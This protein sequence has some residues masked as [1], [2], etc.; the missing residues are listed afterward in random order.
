MKRAEFL[1]NVE[2]ILENREK[3]YGS[4]DAVFEAIA[5]M[6]SAYLTERTGIPVTVTK[7]D[8]AV[9]QIINKIARIGVNM[10]HMDSWADIVGYAACGVE[11]GHIGEPIEQG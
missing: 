5:Q 1:E 2:K 6:I 8:V 7:S 10:G 3:Q 4:P 9:I 11:A